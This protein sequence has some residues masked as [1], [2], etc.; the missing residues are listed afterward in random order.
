MVS[1]FETSSNVHQFKLRLNSYKCHISYKTD[2]R[3]YRPMDGTSDQK[4]K[5]AIYHCVMD[6]ERK[7]F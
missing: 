5:D 6:Y 7:I 1:Q 4:K 2:I 3:Q